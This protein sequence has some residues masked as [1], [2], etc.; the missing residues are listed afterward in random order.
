LSEIRLPKYVF[1][2]RC[3]SRCFADGAQVEIHP[4]V[5][6]SYY[7][8]PRPVCVNTNTELVLLEV[9]SE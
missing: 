5:K 4:E 2:H 1:V 8:A 6:G 9:T 3:D 7:V